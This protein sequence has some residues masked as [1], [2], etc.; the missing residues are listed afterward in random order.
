[1]G[2]V[3]RETVRAEAGATVQAEDVAFVLS[4]SGVIRTGIEE[5]LS[6]QGFQ[7]LGYAVVRADAHLVRE[8]K[9]VAE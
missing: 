4:C 2:R 3:G 9:R 8:R 7:P 6:H 1:M 5:L